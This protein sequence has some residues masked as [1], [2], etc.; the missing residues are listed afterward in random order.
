MLNQLAMHTDLHTARQG[1]V[2]DM[3]AFLHQLD[4][5]G[6][7]VLVLAVDDGIDE[8]IEELFLRAQQRRLDEVHHTVICAVTIIASKSDCAPSQS[9]C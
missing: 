8:A 5:I 3:R 7:G 9:L 1:L 2:Q 6:R 4:V